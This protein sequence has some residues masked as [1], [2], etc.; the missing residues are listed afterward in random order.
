[1]RLLLKLIVLA[2]VPVRF[3][4]KGKGW[5]RGETLFL[6][7]HQRFG[8]SK[9]KET[10]MRLFLNNV[11]IR[12][13]CGNCAFNNKRSLADVTIADYWGIDKQYPAFDDDKGVTLVIVNSEAGAAL[14][15]QIS[16]QAELL[17]TD[18]AKGAEY[19]QAVSKSLPLHPKREFFFEQLDNYTL[20]EMVQEC[21][22]K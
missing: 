12:P 18:F 20:Q 16:S 22:E 19:N 21:L 15:A 4:D 5:K 3:R 9:R 11:S 10:Y 8:A 2:A 14:L 1:M 13:S 6:T 17:P 7:E